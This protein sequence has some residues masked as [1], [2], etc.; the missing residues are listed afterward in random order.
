MVWGMTRP[1]STA[2][3]G[4]TLIE[5]LVVIAVIAILAALLFPALKGAR[6][7]ALRAA[8]KNHIRQVVMGVTTFAGDNDQYLPPSI[9]GTN[10]E[11]FYVKSA[12][13]INA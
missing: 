3:G 13:G 5:L 8:C 7:T 10:A 9:T 1:R 2:S 4:F 6:Q 11:P 12:G